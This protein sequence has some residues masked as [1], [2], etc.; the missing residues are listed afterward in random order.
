MQVYFGDY[1]DFNDLALHLVANYNKYKPSWNPGKEMK[2]QYKDAIHILIIY[3][4]NW[5]VQY[6]CSRGIHKGHWQVMGMSFLETTRFFGGQFC[7]EKMTNKWRRWFD[8]VLGQ[9]NG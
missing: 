6:F 9:R 7:D 5:C 8:N 3:S 1:K 4:F 2:M